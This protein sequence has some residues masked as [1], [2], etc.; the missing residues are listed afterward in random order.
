MV[1]QR[2]LHRLKLPPPVQKLLIGNCS[3]GLRGSK[4]WTGERDQIKERLLGFGSISTTPGLIVA[5][6]AMAVWE[7]CVI[8][9]PNNNQGR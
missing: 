7:C 1:W 5:T 6:V 3:P 2:H 4:T 8:P 9:T